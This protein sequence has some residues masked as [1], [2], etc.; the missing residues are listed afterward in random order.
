MKGQEIYEIRT[1]PWI[2]QV[3]SLAGEECGE[4]ISEHDEYCRGCKALA[5]IELSRIS[6][7]EEKMDIPCCGRDGDSD[8]SR[9]AINNIFCKECSNKWDS[10]SWVKGEKILTPYSS[11]SLS[12]LGRV[13]VSS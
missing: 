6:L 9:P 12:S 5:D 3:G 10:V 11:R 13:A 1:C 4:P 2:F 8:C 7:L